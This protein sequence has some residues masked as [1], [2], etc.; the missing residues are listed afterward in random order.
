M[1]FGTFYGRFVGRT[2]RA[3][4][5]YQPFAGDFDGDG[6]DDVFWYGPESRPD[7]I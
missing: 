7:S 5:D 1:W 4:G 3:D 6:N 2:E